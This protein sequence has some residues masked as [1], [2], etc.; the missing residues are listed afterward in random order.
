MS[1]KINIKGGFLDHN[2][3]CA[4]NL[5]FIEGSCLSLDEL[6]ALAYTYNN[7][8]KQKNMEGEAIKLVND[9][10]K[11]INELDSRF[12]KCNGKQLCWLKQDFIEKTNEFDPNDFFRPNGTDGNR[13]WLSDLNIDL[14]MNQIEKKFPN[15]LFLGSV[16]IDFYEINYLNIA[17]LDFDKLLANGDLDKNADMVEYNL[18][19]FYYKNILLIQEINKFIKNSTKTSFYDFKDFAYDYKKYPKDK[20]LKLIEDFENQFKLP[21]YDPGLINLVKQDFNNLANEF[22]NK[23]IEIRDKVYP[24]KMIGMVPNT[25][26]HDKSG[27]HWIALFANLETGQIYYYDSYGH[28]PNKRIRS[29]VKL[30]A[31]WKY[32]KDTG[33]SLNIPEDQ[34]LKGDDKPKNEIE[35]IYDIRYSE[36]RN[37]FKN[38]ECGVYS[39]NF[40][41]RLLY[42]TKFDEIIK[43]TIDDDTVNKCRE[44]YFNNQNIN[45]EKFTI[46]DDGKKLKIKRGKGYIC[47]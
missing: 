33:K 46:I 24:I 2:L 11:M 15:Y 44:V 37:Q 3:R 31:E 27:Q 42:G 6:K 40:I 23:I 28:R 9:K 29:Y 25:D 5:D 36:I 20:L 43:A 16:P 34:Y 8:L 1:N 19:L 22:T 41:I 4:A 38:S 26:T 7:A 18:K 10:S 21:K 13:D 35:Q 12:K 39:M 14:V 45:N 47:E 30:I 32:K 17:K